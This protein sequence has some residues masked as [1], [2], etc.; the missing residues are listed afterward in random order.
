[1]PPTLYLDCRVGLSLF[2]FQDSQLVLGLKVLS[3]KVLGFYVLVVLFSYRWCF[4][5]GL[6]FYMR[7]GCMILHAHRFY[8]VMFSCICL[9]L[10]L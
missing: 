10:G 4:V 1:M 8:N 5:V 7:T 2:R 6:S 9:V 3:V